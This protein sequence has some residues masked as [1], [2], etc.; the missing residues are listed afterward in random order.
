MNRFS[1]R[2]HDFEWDRLS[3]ESVLA[4][5]AQIRAARKYVIPSDNLR[6]KVIEAAKEYSSDAKGD[7]RLGMIVFASAILLILSM[8]IANRL[9]AWHQDFLVLNSTE[10]Q[11]RALEIC[12][13]KGVGSEWAIVEAFNERRNEQAAKLGVSGMRHPADKNVPTNPLQSGKR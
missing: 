2:D 5:E 11:K 12:S 1:D 4:I 8:P 3:N 10:V 9:Q 13:E 6:P 7:F